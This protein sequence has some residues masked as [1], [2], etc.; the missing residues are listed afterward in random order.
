MIKDVF[1]LWMTAQDQS[2][3]LSGIDCNVTFTV[4]GIAIQGSPAAPNVNLESVGSLDTGLTGLNLLIEQPKFQAP[5]PFW[6]VFGT[7]SGGATFMSAGARIITSSPDFILG[8]LVLAYQ[9][10]QAFF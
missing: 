10:Q 7:G 8:N 4:S 6:P 5:P 1:G 3:G 9:D 2:A